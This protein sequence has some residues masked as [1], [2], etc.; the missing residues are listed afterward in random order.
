MPAVGAVHCTTTGHSDNS[1]PIP[2]TWVGEAGR[3]S[4]MMVYTVAD[5]RLISGEE[6]DV[7]GETNE[8]EIHGAVLMVRRVSR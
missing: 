4:N 7:L 8:T 5:V 2:I 3:W 1:G 6:I